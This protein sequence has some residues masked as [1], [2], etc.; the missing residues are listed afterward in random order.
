MASPVE[1]HEAHAVLAATATSDDARARHLGG[2]TEGRDETRRR[3]ARGGRRQRPGPRRD[4]RRRVA[5]RAGERAHAGGSSRD[6]AIRRAML[7]AECLFIDVSEI[8]QAD[9]ILETAIAAA[10]TGPARAR[11]SA[12][13]RLIR[14]YHGQTPDAVRLGEQALAEVGDEPVLRATVSAGRPSW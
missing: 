2:A 10:P 14:Y 12:S 13:E 3:S 7:A 9:A 6:D 5:V 8:V 4:A 1:L 11:R